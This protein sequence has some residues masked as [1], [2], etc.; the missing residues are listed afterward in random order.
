MDNK[1]CVFCDIITGKAPGRVIMENDLSII[2]LDIHP[3][4]KGHCLAL[5]KR[6]VSW[7]H[8]MTEEET[9]SLFLLAHRAANKMMTAFKPDFVCLYARGRR[10]PH[11]HIFLIPTHGGDTLDRFFNAMEKFQESPRELARL[12][13]DDSLDDA[14]ELLTYYT[15]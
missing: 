9:A 4:S 6:H 2:I 10:I 3:Y 1:S 5:P 13:E 12:S 8:E 11:T 15:V 7:W 14:A